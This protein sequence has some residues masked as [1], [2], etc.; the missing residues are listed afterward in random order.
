M[1]YASPCIGV[2]KMHPEYKV[3]KGCYRKMFEVANW[4][5]F[6]EVEKEITLDNCEMRKELYGELNV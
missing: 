5:N 4:R 2:C 1:I 6:N 3:C